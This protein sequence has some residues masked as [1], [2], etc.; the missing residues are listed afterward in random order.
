[1]ATGPP[2]RHQRLPVGRQ[3]QGVWFTHTNRLHCQAGFES[4]P[5]P[6]RMSL[7][8][9]FLPVI[10]LLGLAA[11]D[12]L[13]RNDTTAPSTGSARVRV[14]HVA[15]TAPAVDIARAGSTIAS[16]VA[17]GSVSPATGY[18]TSPAGQ[19][20]LTVSAGGTAVWSAQAPLVRDSAHTIVALGNVGAAF[21]AGSARSFQPI[22][23]KDTAV[24]APATAAWLRIVHAAD[25][26]AVNASN[27]A[28]S[29]VDIYIY[30][31]GTPRPT[32]APAAGTA[33]RILNAAYRAVTAY[34]ALTT[35]GPYTVEVFVAGATPAS[36]TPLIATTVTL[37]TAT[38]TTVVA[39]RASPTA[40]APL[41]A[42]GLILLPET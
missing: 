38:K 23:L 41:N 11:C 13:E 12:G 18:A 42:F 33:L 3:A 9:Q 28:T 1:M 32:A 4:T 26:V 29:N 5:T 35:A 24:A 19:G 21:P 7:S 36:A 34:Q 6:A 2:A 17:F 14:V 25:S 27:V 8:R 16:A 30:P 31:Q 22:V 39:R 10:G 15:A 37:A 20:V 40:A